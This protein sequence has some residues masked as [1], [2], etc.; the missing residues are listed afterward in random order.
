LWLNPKWTKFDKG[1]LFTAA[2]QTFPMNSSHLN[3]KN[4]LRFLKWK[5]F[6]KLF[7]K[8]KIQIKHIRTFL[9]E[10]QK[11]LGEMKKELKLTS[12]RETL[13]ILLGATL[14]G[15]A[16]EFSVQRQWVW[17]GKWAARRFFSNPLMREFEPEEL[18]T[19]F[20]GDLM[21]KY[22]HPRSAQIITNAFQYVSIETKS[23]LFD[24]AVKYR[25][26]YYSS[27]L[28]LYASSQ[29]SA[30]ELFRRNNMPLLAQVF[31]R[32]DL[33]FLMAGAALYERNEF[34][35]HFQTQVDFSEVNVYI[36]TSN[37]LELMNKMDVDETK[38]K[39]IP[40]VLAEHQ[41]AK[42]L[43]VVGDPTAA[44]SLRRKM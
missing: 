34:L 39:N 37:W 17:S 14:Y 2:S 1:V 3:F 24:R 9:E 40:N 22:T 30:L 11:S 25:S 7:A 18:A 44:V 12:T 21:R 38:W 33:V 35:N 5:P 23:L 4:P 42:I 10:T 13:K 26:A 28:A 19:Y 16:F 31:R 27:Q 15:S 6:S 8:L 32:Y 20:L 43:D 29:T 36:Q 41:R